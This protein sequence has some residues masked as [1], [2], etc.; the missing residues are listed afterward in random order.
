[1]CYCEKIEF[2]D[3]R[4]PVRTGLNVYHKICGRQLTKDQC[5]AIL[6]RLVKEVSV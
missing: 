4:L 6:T 1:M 2:Q 3:L 5:C